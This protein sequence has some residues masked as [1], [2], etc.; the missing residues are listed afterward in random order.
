MHNLT[1]TYMTYYLYFQE[2]LYELASSVRKLAPESRDS[3]LFALEVRI[4]FYF[5]TF[6]TMLISCI[7]LGAS[8]GTRQAVDLK[9]TRIEFQANLAYLLSFSTAGAEI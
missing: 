7:A 5:L 2:Y 6:L 9:L 3:H 4:I 1:K 8:E